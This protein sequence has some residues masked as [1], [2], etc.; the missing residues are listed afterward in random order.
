MG[1]LTEVCLAFNVVFFSSWRAVEE[2]ETTEG[3]LVEKVEV[4]FAREKVVGNATVV[5]VAE[6]GVKATTAVETAA[7][8]REVSVEVILLYRKKVIHAVE[9]F[10]V[11]RTNAGKHKR[12]QERERA[13]QR[14][15]S[16]EECT[17]RRR[18][19][20]KKQSNQDEKKKRSHRY[21]S[22]VNSMVFTGSR[23]MRRI[24]MQQLPIHHSSRV[25]HY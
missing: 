21:N 22:C 2:E 4:I 24:S 5:V 18:S 10:L 25:E 17:H 20:T 16:G 13:S 11:Y 12:R 9:S 7:V 23:Q 8:D 14:Q 15:Q 19:T 1:N 3:F 6:E